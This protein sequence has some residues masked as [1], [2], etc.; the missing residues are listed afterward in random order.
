MAVFGLKMGERT[1]SAVTAQK[2]NPNR[3]NVFLDGEY[4]FS[5]SRIVAAWLQPGKRLDQ[6]EIDAL[7]SQDAEEKVLQSAMRLLNYRLRSERE[8]RVR[9]QQKGFDAEKID[10]VVEKLRTS[11][12]LRDDQFAT[13]WVDSRNEFHPRSQKLMRYELKSK[14][15]SEKEIEEALQS[16]ADDRELALRAARKVSRRYEN[17][18]WL[19]FRAKVSGH[20]ARKGFT[21]EVITP[22]VKEMWEELQ[23]QITLLENE[24]PGK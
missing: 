23:N 12:A 6:K 19:E 13:A 14:G 4:G 17:L 18:P 16:S 2:R 20:L 7:M 9:L 8:V 22:V 11:G 10:C 5:L 21:Y 15:I 1:V 24:E 3:V